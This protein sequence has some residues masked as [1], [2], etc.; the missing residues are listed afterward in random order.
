MAWPKEVD[1]L[2]ATDICRGQFN[3]PNK[4]HCI[5]GWLRHWFGCGLEYGKAEK[6]AH[7]I[8]H[9][10]SLMGWNDDP[11]TKK[12]EIART[13]NKVT[14]ALGYTENNPEA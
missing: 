11:N 4:T 2:E 14:A 9:T 13:I 6:I 8:A 3:G 1:V 10:H 7:R 12:A 5:V